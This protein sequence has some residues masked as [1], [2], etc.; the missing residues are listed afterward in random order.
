[1]NNAGL[2]VRQEEGERLYRGT[3]QESIPLDLE[4][5]NAALRPSGFAIPATCFLMWVKRCWQYTEAAD[6][7]RNM[8]YS[9]LAQDLKVKP[10]QKDKNKTDFISLL[11]YD[12]EQGNMQSQFLE[13][14]AST[15]YI[16]PH[17]FLSLACNAKNRVTLLD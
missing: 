15:L 12:S 10:F 2:K 17:E 7:E 1:M 14:I 4:Q 6:I 11:S 16:F 3:A 13:A 8:T 9:P 5:I